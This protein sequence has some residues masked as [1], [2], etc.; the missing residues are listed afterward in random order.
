ME[1]SGVLR[2]S[3]VLRMSVDGQIKLIYSPNAPELGYK[4][5]NDFNFYFLV[6]IFQLFYPDQPRSTLNMD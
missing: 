1:R 3:R 5:E 4:R 6:S 2:V